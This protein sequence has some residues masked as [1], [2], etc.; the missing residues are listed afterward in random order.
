[1][2][3]KYQAKGGKL[4]REAFEDH[5]DQAARAMSGYFLF[6]PPWSEMREIAFKHILGVCAK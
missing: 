6:P 2:F 4:S 5:L 1:M 3:E